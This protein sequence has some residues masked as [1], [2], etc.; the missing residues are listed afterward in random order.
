[1][2]ENQPSPSATNDIGKTDAHLGATNSRNCNHHSYNG[3][4]VQLHYPDHEANY[5]RQWKLFL[6]FD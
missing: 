2:S 6:S 4:D 5:P 3:H 1:M